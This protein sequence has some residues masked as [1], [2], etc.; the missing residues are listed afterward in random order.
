MLVSLLYILHIPL[1]SIHYRRMFGGVELV[2]WLELEIVRGTLGGG[3]GGRRG[4]LIVWMMRLVESCG[5]Y[6]RIVL[7]VVWLILFAYGE[8]CYW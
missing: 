4:V 8:W 3:L 2:L 6:S 1:Q 5:D 7:L